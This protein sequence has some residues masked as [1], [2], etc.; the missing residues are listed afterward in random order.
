[1]LDEQEAL[2]ILRESFG[3]QVS[4]D[5][6]IGIGDD[7]AAVSAD[8]GKLMLYST[9]SLVE[10]VHFV[11]EHFKPEEIAA[12]AVAVSLSD[13]AAMGGTPRFILS[14]VGFP[15]CT[16]KRTI[17][18]IF[19]GLKVATEK[20]GINLI[21]GNVTSSEKILIDITVI[22]ETD[23]DEVVRREG[24]SSGDIIY[25]TGTLG[26]SSLGLKMLYEPK[27]S[28]GLLV[29][30][31]KIPVARI[32][33]GREIAARRL[34]NSMIDISDGL[35]LDLERITV[36]YGLGADIYLKN[37]PLSQ[38]YCSLISDYEEDRYVLALT[39]GED[40]ELLFTASPEKKEQLAD[41]NGYGGIRISEVGTVTESGEIEVYD[42]DGSSIEYSSRG[43][44]HKF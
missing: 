32:E 6:R 37:I 12:K 41:L 16:N 29:E 34:A 11:K 23:E 24:G 26:D 9:D 19:A 7:C 2:N 1:M 3:Q 21:G 25:T 14:S 39:G 27:N 15:A 18:G 13:I 8:G 10:D 17:E 33:I 20:Y 35:L 43:Y 38:Q 31:H 40:Y 42:D 5:L 44:L 30:R 36:E 22:G 4:G 28:S